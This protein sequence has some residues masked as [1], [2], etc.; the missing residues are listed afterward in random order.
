MDAARK[1]LVM[2]I[3]S[4]YDT[5]SGD[6]AKF[7]EET[8]D[9]MVDLACELVRLLRSCKDDLGNKNSEIHT[10]KGQTRRRGQ[11]YL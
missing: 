5:L 10:P 6:F 4:F 7:H 8:G 11:S 3:A 2:F 1:A 9:F